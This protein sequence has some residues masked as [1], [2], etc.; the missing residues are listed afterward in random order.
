MAGMKDAGTLSPLRG[1]GCRRGAVREWVE[2]SPRFAPSPKGV[3]PSHVEDE[4]TSSVQSQSEKFT[5]TSRISTPCS[6]RV[7]HELGRRIK[8]IGWAFSIAAQKTSG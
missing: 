2:M 6:R 4:A 5:S 3:A 8:P 7:A 1:E